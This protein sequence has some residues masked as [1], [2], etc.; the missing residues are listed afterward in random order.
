MEVRDVRELRDFAYRLVHPGGRCLCAGLGL[1]GVPVCL[2]FLSSGVRLLNRRGC[3]SRDARSGVAVSD[4]QMR[5]VDSHQMALA[6]KPSQPL[7]AMTS[8]CTG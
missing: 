6:S 8:G 1:G 5:G 2:L 3:I 7:S 4:I